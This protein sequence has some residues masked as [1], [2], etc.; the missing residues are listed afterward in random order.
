MSK[1]LEERIKSHISSDERDFSYIKDAMTRIEASQKKAEENHWAHVQSYMGDMSDS[2]KKLTDALT[3]IQVDLA[4]QKTT[5]GSHDKLLWIV[6]SA[7][8][9]TLITAIAG[10]VL[11]FANKS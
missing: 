3:Q 11:G 2:F 6:I 1:Q 5:V 4:V 9:G 8:V 10:I 7:S